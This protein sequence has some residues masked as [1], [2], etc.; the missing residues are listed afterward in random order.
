MWSPRTLRGVIR[1]DGIVWL[2]EGVASPVLRYPADALVVIGGPSGAG[3]S[4][5]AARVVPA[6]EVIDADDVRAALAAERGVALGAIDWPE[7][8]ARTRAQYAERLATGRGAVVVAT[9]LRH[10]HRLGLAKDA[11]AAGVG[12]HLLLLD[13]TAEECR[14]G[15]AAQGE[16]RIADGLF[17]HLLREWAAFRR[18]LAAGAHPPGIASVTILD[19]AAAG[20]LERIERA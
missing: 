10:G 12:C 13:A 5:L 8:L 3:K 1:R 14:A 20:G 7:A 15:R 17:E 19:R 9:A 11:M 6:G 16:A 18:N 4:T 2:T